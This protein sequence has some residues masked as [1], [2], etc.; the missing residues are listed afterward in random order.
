MASERAWPSRRRNDV[1]LEEPRGDVP[2]APWRPVPFRDRQPARSLGLRAQV[3][4]GFI[5]AATGPRSRIPPLVRS[6]ARRPDLT[7]RAEGFGELRLDGQN[8]PRPSNE[9][10]GTG[11]VPAAVLVED[12]PAIADL[13]LNLGN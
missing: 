1:R 6:Y 8:R 4:T 11:R 13:A 10:I 5:V 2:V 12:V 3:R 9:C 7:T